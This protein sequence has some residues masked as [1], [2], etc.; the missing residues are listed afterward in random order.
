MK[1]L[2]PKVAAI[3]GV[4]ALSACAGMSDTQQRTLS[5]AGIGAAGGAVIGAI[6]GNAGLG[7]VIGTAVGA[8]G[9]YLYDRH[10]KS[11]Q[12]SYDQGYQAGKKKSKSR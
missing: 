2:V 8:G 6:G 7:A 11:E 4:L 1:E 3:V 5:G 12:R 9:G 10:K